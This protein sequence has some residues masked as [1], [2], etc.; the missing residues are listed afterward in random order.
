VSVP[1]VTL[2]PEPRAGSGTGA[3]VEPYD[4]QTRQQILDRVGRGDFWRWDE[5]LD[6]CGGCARPVR[7]RGRF[8][9]RSRNGQVVTYSTE[10]EPDGVLLVR[11]GNR[12]AAVCPSC[13]FEYAGDVWHLIAA[14]IS[15]GH[16]GV[17]AGVGDHAKVFASLTAPGFGPVHTTPNDKH[18]RRA[19]CRSRGKKTL[20]EH[21]RPTRCMK[22][23]A[24]DDP[25]LGEPLCAGCYDYQASAAFNWLAPEL[26]RRF[27]ITLSRTL[28]RRCGMSAK[29]FERLVTVQ[30][31]K[32]A[33]F[34]RRGVVHFHAIIRLDGRIHPDETEQW[35]APWL[36]ITSEQLADAIRDA[37]SRVQVFVELGDGEG[38]VLRFG[39]QVN[40]QPLT[41]RPNLDTG[42]L[43]AEQV[44]AY[45]AKYATKAAEEL[46]LGERRDVPD[47]HHARLR[48][49]TGH[50]LR[51]L[52]AADQLGDLEDFAGI[53]RWLHMLGFRGHF[54]TK[55]RRYSTTMGALREERRIFRRRQGRRLLGQLHD[56]TRDDD[57]DR[58]DT[59]LVIARW[60][61]AGIGYLNAGDAAL[62][63][64]AA[65]RARERR[66]AAAEARR[67]HR[68]M[69][70]A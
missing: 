67:D 10:E 34:Q 44:A 19:R 43:K 42:E 38:L 60:E 17:S 61:F 69:H 29:A 4:P 36:D 33:E 18:G 50:V 11:C 31:A 22:V 3:A 45:V 26:W 62:A 49:L 9:E 52:E 27:T 37:A 24:D 25:R 7:L 23:H 54:A 20:C 64:S 40:A 51:L 13:S 5:Q 21:G 53:R 47:L 58:E 8:V 66:Q 28:A 46:G 1:A 48:G 6:R 30:Y 65:A 56:Q 39:E 68:T 15:G 32:V 70:A 55:S 16:K 14:G 57:R 59:T 2:V 63:A 35:P 41:R 12:R